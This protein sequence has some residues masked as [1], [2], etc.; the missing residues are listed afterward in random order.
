[1]WFWYPKDSSIALT[2]YVEADHA[3]CQDTRRSTSGNSLHDKEQVE[4]GVVEALLC[5]RREGQCEVLC[6]RQLK[7]L[8]NEGLRIVGSL[9]WDHLRVKSEGLRMLPK[10]LEDSVEHYKYEASD[11]TRPRIYSVQPNLLVPQ[12]T[13]SILLFLTTLDDPNQY[14]ALDQYSHASSANEILPD[15]QRV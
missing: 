4:N 3:G 13:S 9:D 10:D 11:H 1:M 15:C 2:V 5:Q 7:Q 12:A 6:L 14:E 8:A